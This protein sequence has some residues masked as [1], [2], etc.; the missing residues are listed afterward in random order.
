LHVSALRWLGSNSAAAFL[1]GGVAGGLPVGELV[2][3]TAAAAADWVSTRRSGVLG[4]GA[5]GGLA[6]PTAPAAAA[7]DGGVAGVVAAVAAAVVAVGDA[8]IGLGGAG[9]WCLVKAWVTTCWR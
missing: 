5:E 2:G 9:C 6:L 1:D 3:L 7:G 8:G 4:A